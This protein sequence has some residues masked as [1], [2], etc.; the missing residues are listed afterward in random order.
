MIRFSYE[1]IWNILDNVIN[2]HYF[3]YQII[4]KIWEKIVHTLKY[5]I[6]VLKLSTHTPTFLKYCSQYMYVSMHIW[7][8]FFNY[9][10]KFKLRQHKYSAMFYT[11]TTWKFITTICN[12]MIHWWCMYMKNKI[13]K[14][15][16]ECIAA[17]CFWVL[18]HASKPSCIT[19]SLF[20]RKQGMA[21]MVAASRPH[22]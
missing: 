15:C 21:R 1:Y 20:C 13:I 12:F 16:I 19:E 11:C 2:I 22:V 14:I 7:K 8:W 5:S 10:I 9:N 17:V 4:I 3:Y 18:L 6:T